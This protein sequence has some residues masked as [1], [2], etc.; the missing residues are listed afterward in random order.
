MFW[1]LIKKLRKNPRG[2]GMK[3]EEEKAVWKKLVYPIWRVLE[4][5][6][7]TDWSGCGR[8]KEGG[9]RE[10]RKTEN[11]G[12]EKQPRNGQV[13]VESEVLWDDS[14]AF[15]QIGYPRGHKSSRYIGKTIKS[16][17]MKKNYENL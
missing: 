5:E 16:R 10:E 9:T 2:V 8:K 11:V 12:I 14:K 17:K 15:C 7:G 1:T 13:R 4:S 3:K 6:Q